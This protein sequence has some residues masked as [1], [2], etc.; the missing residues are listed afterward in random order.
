MQ[1]LPVGSFAMAGDPEHPAKAAGSIREW[2]VDGIAWEIQSALVAI[3]LLLVAGIVALMFDASITVVLVVMV[4]MVLAVR[5]ARA[6][7]RWLGSPDPA[8]RRPPTE[9]MQTPLPRVCRC[10][11]RAVVTVRSATCGYR[12]CSRR[13]SGTCTACPTQ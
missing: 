4:G 9:E 10:L 12:T 5:L 7:R 11:D 3:P 1:I 13:S 8:R 2:F 6:V